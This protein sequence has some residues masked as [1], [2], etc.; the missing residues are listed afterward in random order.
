MFLR[1]KIA[2]FTILQLCCSIVYAQ[3]IT[4]K[5][6]NYRDRF[7]NEFI[8]ISP[9]VEEF[10][11]NIPAIDRNVDENNKPI[12]I[13]WSDG[14]SNFNHWLGV[15]ATEYRLLKN[16]N[17]DYSETLNM[18]VYTMLALERLD[19][20]SEY[21]IRVQDSIFPII[22]GD[23][24]KEFIVYPDDINGFLIRDDVSLGFW[25][26][27]SKHFNVWIGN[28][29]KTRDGT[30]TYTSV[31]KH[32]VIQ[33]EGQSQ[34]N[35]IRLL[36]GL[37]IVKALCE[38]ESLENVHVKFINPLIP[39]YLFDNTILTGD[40]VYFD[41]WVD[42]LTQRLVGQMQ[43]P[44]PEKK[45]V[46]KPMRGMAELSKHNLF[47]VLSSRWYIMNPVKNDVVAEGSGEDMGVWMNSYG[48]AE[49][50][51]AITGTDT[52]H[53]DGSRYGISNY[54]FKAFLTKQLYV[55]PGGAIPLPRNFDDYM[56]R[57]LASI[58]DINWHKNSTQLF[59]TLRDRRE[60]LTYEHE[61]LILYILHH[62]KYANFYAKGSP[63]YEADK[64]YFYNL[65]N[66]APQSGPNDNINS[67][68]YAPEW[69]SSSRLIWP[70]ISRCDKHSGSWHS[71]FAGLDYMLLHNLYRLI[72][73]ADE[74]VSP[75]IRTNAINNNK[76]GKY[77]EYTPTYDAWFFYEAPKIKLSQ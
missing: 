72:F 53:L 70:R 55:L 31:F 10:G 18:L 41:R 65:L 26:K 45:M 64:E 20:Y 73:D 6:W 8:L 27:H 38:T 12:W 30:N 22:N 19:L 25:L 56:F 63:Y 74:F 24:I 51:A 16:N 42:N 13:S 58:G 52:F 4:E 71:D 29:N 44:F 76:Y 2:L 40:S 34:D 35:I 3:D 11:T 39:Q 37:A 50:A 14:N 61:V 54:L 21:A 43:H 7:L 23:T 32:G 67:S 69:S 47:G 60:A 5:Y 66:K 68:D 15:L 33:K 1:F 49:A 9:N 46:F 77:P 17:Q 48:I 57:D 36:Q 59:H 75:E 28:L 62:E